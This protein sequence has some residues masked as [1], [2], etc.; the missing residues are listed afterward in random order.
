MDYSLV[1]YEDGFNSL[2]PDQ[3]E[4]LEAELFGKK[5]KL[6]KL[7][8]GLGKTFKTYQENK[9]ERVKA[10]QAARSERTALRAEGK[11]AKWGAKAQGAQSGFESFI[12]KASGLIPGMQ[13]SAGSQSAEYLET[14]DADNNNSKTI[15]IVVVVLLVVGVAAYFML[16]K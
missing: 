14:K 8:L 15:I 3:L 11:A 16:K 2:Y 4:D 9:T 5:I 10:R 6:P 1:K 13:S 12:D 7:D